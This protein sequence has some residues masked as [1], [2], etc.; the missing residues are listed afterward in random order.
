VRAPQVPASQPPTADDLAL[1]LGDEVFFDEE[2]QD[3]AFEGFTEE[4]E[5]LEKAP[6]EEIPAEP[7]KPAA[8]EPAKAPVKIAIPPAKPAPAAE[9][10]A[11]LLGK[12]ATLALM[13]YLK[14]LTSSLP[15]R[16]KFMFMRS[17][18]KQKMEKVITRLG[19]KNGDKN[20]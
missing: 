5:I 18:V 3:D 14:N 4:E 13:D 8:P 1:D 11:D 16:E 10:N 2:D 6:D 12:D 20:A 17:D 9:A 7:Q 15:T 19:G